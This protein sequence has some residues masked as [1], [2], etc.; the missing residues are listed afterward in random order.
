MLNKEI[1]YIVSGLERSGTSLMMQ[2]LHKGGLPVASDD[3]RAADENN[4]RGYYELEG[5]KII[6]RLMDGTFDL[7]SHRGSIIK[8]TAYGL[9]FLPQSSYKIIYMMRNIDEVLKSM[10]KMGAD[11]DEEKDRTLFS[12][13]NIFSFELM[14]S[15]DDMEHIEVNYRDL[16]GDPRKEMERVNRFIG[17]TF[18]VD[19]AIK[20]VEPGLYRNKAASG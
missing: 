5:G 4:P 9:K 18:D 14:R 16:I 1:N 12:K 6:N 17:E 8:I 15:R 19:T 11:V 10:Q 20:A 3:S 2:M 13:L 7:Q